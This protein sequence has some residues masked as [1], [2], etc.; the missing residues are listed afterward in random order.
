[1]I[2]SRDLNHLSPWL[3]KKAEQHVNLCKQDGIDLLIYCTYRD[4]EAQ[5]FEYAKGR[6]APG[7]IVTKAQ[8]GE[9]AHNVV[10]EEKKPA[11]MAYDCVPIIDGVPVWDKNDPVWQRVGSWGESIGLLWAGRWTTFKEYPHFQQ[12]GFLP[13]ARGEGKK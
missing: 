8:A 7:H 10:D 1:M 5:N 12:P 2:S 9:S 6:T 13:K 3:K 4:D 11:A